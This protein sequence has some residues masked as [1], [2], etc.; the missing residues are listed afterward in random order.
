MRDM[1]LI[2]LKCNPFEESHISE[3]GFLATASIEIVII[4]GEC[5]QSLLH[6][7]ENQLKP[8]INHGPFEPEEDAIVT[9]V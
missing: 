2:A 5:L 7:W 3:I 6:R 1:H 4:K 9:E 8:D